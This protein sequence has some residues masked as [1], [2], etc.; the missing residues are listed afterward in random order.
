MRKLRFKTIFSRLLFLQIATLLAAIIIVGAVL[1]TVVHVQR[2]QDTKS[3][4]L[5]KAQSLTA[6]LLSAKEDFPSEA[7][8]IAKEHGVNIL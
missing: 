5:E 2:I 3:M 6:V 1:I 4:L 7:Q 8:M